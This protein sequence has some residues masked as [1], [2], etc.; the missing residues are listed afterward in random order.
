MTPY[1]SK[2]RFLSRKAWLT[3]GKAR[4]A[5]NTA[6]MTN[7]EFL[8]GVLAGYSRDMVRI[9]RQFMQTAVLYRQMEG[10]L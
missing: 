8:R 3:L 10:R 6:V 1:A 4:E 2:A 5:R 7:D 9:A